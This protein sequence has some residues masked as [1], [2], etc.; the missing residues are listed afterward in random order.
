MYVRDDL[1]ESSV[2]ILL[3]SELPELQ[4]CVLCLRVH[5]RVLAP[6][7]FQK[8]APAVNHPPFPHP[9]L[10][11]NHP[12]SVVALSRTVRPPPTMRRVACLEAIAS[13]LGL[14]ASAISSRTWARRAPGALRITSVPR[15]FCSTSSSSSSSSSSKHD[16]AV[17]SDGSGGDDPDEATFDESFAVRDVYDTRPCLRNVSKEDLRSSST[18]LAWLVREKEDEC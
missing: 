11:P 3:F 14:Q 1:E 16:G 13:S 7:Q 9:P 4:A 15:R 2:L 12:R 17:E 8:Q 18:R 10:P 5:H 6:H